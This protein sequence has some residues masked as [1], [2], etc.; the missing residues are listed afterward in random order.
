MK[1]AKLELISLPKIIDTRGNL[2]FL[3][4]FN[5]IPF[6]IASVYW[7]YDVLKD[8]CREGEG[9]AYR[10]TTELIIPLSGSFT[11]EIIERKK[12]SYFIMD[13][14]NKGLIVPSMTWRRLID[15]LPGSICL[16]ATNTKYSEMEHIYNYHEYLEGYQ[17]S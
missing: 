17:N 11:I 14:T 1:A 7:I 13:Q 3:E 2:S 16:V 6:K 5:Q 12:P 9:Y 10:N 15:F 4:D 8:Q